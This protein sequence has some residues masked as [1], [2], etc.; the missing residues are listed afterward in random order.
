MGLITLESARCQAAPVI[1]LEEEQVSTEQVEA[2]WEYLVSIA[3]DT[4]LTPRLRVAAARDALDVVARLV[5]AVPATRA[6]N[7]R[8]ARRAQRQAEVTA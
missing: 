6:G 1:R 2:A 8:A 3:Q 7:V 5:G 4:E